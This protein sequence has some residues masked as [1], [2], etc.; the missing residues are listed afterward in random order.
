MSKSAI[1]PQHPALPSA[2]PGL[3][4]PGAMISAVLLAA[5]LASSQTP[6]PRPEYE[7]VSIKPNTS[8]TRQVW[9]TGAGNSGRM[10]ATNVSL[11]MLITIAY[12]V[13]NFQVSGGGSFLDSDRYDVEAKP[14]EGKFTEAE[15]L[16]MLQSLLEDRFK[17]EVH[18]ERKEMPVYALLPAKTGI[19]IPDFKEGSCTEFDPNTP[20]APRQPSQPPTMYCGNFMMG[21]DTLMGSKLRMAAFTDALSNIL[22]RTVVDK[23]GVT[24]AFNVRLEFTR[25][26]V[27][28]FGPNGAGAPG[29]ATEGPPADSTRP[30]IFTAIQEQLGL[31]LESEKGPVEV[32]VV[33]HA[34]KASEN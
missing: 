26:G 15:Y 17:L 30:T 4:I 28:N 10:V 16:A 32:L 34:E 27:A 21:P 19:K 23:T 29:P 5:G 1:S 6:A 31:R 20:Q 18:R 7:V 13:K 22:G 25:D 33:D 24:G 3:S 9:I 8:G 2:V 11:R 14:P 12:K